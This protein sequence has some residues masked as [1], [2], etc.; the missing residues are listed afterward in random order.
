MPNL[1]QT[2][3]Y[4]EVTRS[5]YGVLRSHNVPPAL[6]DELVEYFGKNNHSGIYRYVKARGKSNLEYGMVFRDRPDKVT[7]KYAARDD[8]W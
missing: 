8:A 4:G 1:I 3:W 5:L 2:D 7:G 6:Y